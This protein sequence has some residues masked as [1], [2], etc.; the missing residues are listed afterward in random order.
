MYSI[1]WMTGFPFNGLNSK[2]VFI[3]LKGFTYRYSTFYKNWED[4]RPKSYCKR[5]HIQ[6]E[7]H[8]WFLHF[9]SHLPHTQTYVWLA[10]ADIPKVLQTPELH[11]RLLQPP[12][13]VPQ[14]S[15]ESGQN[16]FIHFQRRKWKNQQ[17]HW[18]VDWQCLNI[19]T[20]LHLNTTRLS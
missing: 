3:V 9:S 18:G 8:K 10:A 11:A 7:P 20:P 13:Y 15:Q 5:P 6:G 14:F 19:F 16:V 4:Q 1:Y 17:Q 2:A 12:V